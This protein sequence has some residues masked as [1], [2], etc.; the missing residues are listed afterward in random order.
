VR[1][2]H[3]IALTRSN[4]TANTASVLAAEAC[5]ERNQRSH[6]AYF[7][8]RNWT[9]VECGGAGDCFFYCIL[10]IKKVFMELQIDMFKTHQALRK[11]VV[12]HMLANQDEIRVNDQPIRC[13]LDKKGAHWLKKMMKSHEYI[14]YEVI[15]GFAHMA[16]AA[17]I[18]YTV[19]CSSPLVRR[20]NRL[21]SRLLTFQTGNIPERSAPWEQV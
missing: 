6:F 12:N 7:L 17:V 19:H 20:R 5:C 13:L 15:C 8:N 10:H 16:D 11:Q 14:E 4:D 18:V 9:V 1:Q 2:A 3:P 21:F